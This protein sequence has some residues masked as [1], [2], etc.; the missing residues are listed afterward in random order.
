MLIINNTEFLE[1]FHIFNQKI[2]ALINKKELV[3]KSQELI[4]ETNSS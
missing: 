2:Q 3:R 4:S 1:P